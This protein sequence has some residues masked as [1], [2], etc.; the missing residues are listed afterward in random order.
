MISRV[1]ARGVRGDKKKKKR[2][3]KRTGG[4]PPVILHEI[5]EGHF[6]VVLKGF[7]ELYFGRDVYADKL[8][9]VGKT[10]ELYGIVNCRYFVCSVAVILAGMEE[11]ISVG[12]YSY[13]SNHRD[14]SP[15][16]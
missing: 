5:V 7:R 4:I 2:K 14:R 11:R 12:R 3:R 10:I 1:C 8:E 13:C 16:G 6:G 15:S 9:R